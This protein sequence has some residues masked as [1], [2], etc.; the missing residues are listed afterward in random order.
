SSVQTQREV[1]GLRAMNRND[2][3]LQVQRAIEQSDNDTI[4]SVKIVSSN[5]LKSGDL[6]IKTASSSEVETLRQFADDWSHRNGS[7]NTV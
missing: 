6:S 2:L 1:M 4:A 5:Q 7:G 3:N